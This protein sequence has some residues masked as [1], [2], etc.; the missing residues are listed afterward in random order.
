MLITKKYEK[1]PSM[2]SMRVLAAVHYGLPVDAGAKSRKGFHNV[3]RGCI[4]NGALTE[5]HQLTELGL[6]HLTARSRQV[7]Q[8]GKNT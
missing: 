3:V 2:A 7:L 5:D 8:H 6:Q 4:A 1:F